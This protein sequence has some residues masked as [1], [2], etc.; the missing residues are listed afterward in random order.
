MRIFLDSA[1]VDIV[2]EMLAQYPLLSGVTTNPTILAREKAPPL[3][4]L[5]MLR[6]IVG[7]GLL[8]AQVLATDAHTMTLEALR[9]VDALGE[10]TVVKLPATAEGLSA[11]RTLRAA[12]ATVT[13]T[14]CFTPMQGALCALA[15]ASYVVPFISRIDAAGDGLAVAREMVETLRA[16]SLSA[17]VL[18]GSFRTARQVAEV[19]RAG[20]TNITVSPEILP[21]LIE[22]TLTER[23]VDAFHADFA[24]LTGNENTRMEWLQ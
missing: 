9:L 14:A 12:G 7:H 19:C 1:N 8:F 20:V 6:D 15:G 18:A 23:A 22:N 21:Q 10:H 13:A 4:R 2:S 3:S 11:M 24:A 16:Q 5:R 17:E